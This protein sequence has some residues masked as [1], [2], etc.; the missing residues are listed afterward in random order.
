MY[1]LMLCVFF[2]LCFSCELARAVFRFNKVTDAR[3]SV[4]ELNTLFVEGNKK[5][6]NTMIYTVVVMKKTTICS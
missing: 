6:S 4:F 3:E 1:V 2:F 5:T